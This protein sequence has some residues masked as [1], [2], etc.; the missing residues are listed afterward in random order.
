[1]LSPKSGFFTSVA[2]LPRLAFMLKNWLMVKICQPWS[3]VSGFLGLLFWLFAPSYHRH[4]Q[5]KSTFVPN[6]AF[7]GLF[8]FWLF[9]AAYKDLWSLFKVIKADFFKIFKKILSSKD[10]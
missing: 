5:K 9:V 6:F 8:L 2:A 1:M 10:L 3:L 7:F 4:R